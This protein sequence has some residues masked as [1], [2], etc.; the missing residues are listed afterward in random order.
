MPTLANGQIIA[1]PP[2]LYQPPPPPKLSGSMINVAAEKTLENQQDAAQAYMKLG[3]GQKGGGPYA[4][5]PELP[6]GGTIPGVSYEKNYVKGIDT[7]NQLRANSAYDKYIKA[8]PMQVKAGGKRRLRTKKKHGRSRNR[9]R[10]GKHRSHSR[11]GRRRSRS[12]V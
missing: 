10:R 5:V 9:T 6:E 11:R 4:Y 3:A 1:A 8:P 7:L 2:K 12:V